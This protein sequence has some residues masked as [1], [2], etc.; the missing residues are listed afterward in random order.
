MEELNF[1]L[2]TAIDPHILDEEWATQSSLYMEYCKQW[3]TESKELDRLKKQ[4]PIL[5]AKVGNDIRENPGNYSYK[6][7]VDAVN[8]LIASNEEVIAMN[9]EIIEKTYTVN[10]LRGAL[11]ALDHKKKA[12]ENLVMLFGLNYFSGPSEAK[13]I[14]GG[15]R[16]ANKNR[17]NISQSIRTKMNKKD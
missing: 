9:N 13:T 15:K 4:L 1:E 17:E 5:E 8:N 12:L 10:L 14:T 2:D 16:F 11:T 7:T 6:L 3:A